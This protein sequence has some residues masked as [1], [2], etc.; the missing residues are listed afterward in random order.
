M[1]ARTWVLLGFA[2]VA[3]AGLSRVPEP[4]ELTR[5]SGPRAAEDLVTGWLPPVRRR[6]VAALVVDLLAFVPLY[7]ALGTALADEAGDDTWGRVGLAGVVTGAAAD[8]VEDVTALAYVRTRSAR[9][10]PAMRWAGRAKHFAS[11]ALVALLGLAL[12]R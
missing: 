5:A 9:L 11:I 10:V 6:A 12:L 2:G 3:F 7:T 8:V 1:A 4:L